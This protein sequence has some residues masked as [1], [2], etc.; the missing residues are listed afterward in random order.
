MRRKAFFILLLAAVI[1]LG[2]CTS[3]K[4][5]GQDDSGEKASYDLGGKTRCEAR[6]A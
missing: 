4:T 1:L 5:D 6:I 3:A 2:G